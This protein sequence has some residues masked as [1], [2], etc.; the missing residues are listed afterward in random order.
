MAAVFASGTVTIMGRMNPPDARVSREAQGRDH[1]PI[2]VDLDGTL[3]RTDV[4]WES[5]VSALRCNVWR[6]LCGLA[7]LRHGKAAMKRALADAGPVDAAL[8]PYNEIFVEWLRSE[9][10]RGRPLILATAAD[11]ALAKSVAA[12]LGFFVDVIASDGRRNL[13]GLGKLDA[14]QAHRGDGAFA[15]CGNGPE[16]I[17]I[18]R[19][20]DEAILV[21]G[22]ARVQARASELPGV[23]R[24]FS[25]GET[26]WRTWLRGMRAHQWLKNLLVLVPLVTA[27][28][29]N[30]AGMVAQAFTAFVA[31][32][33]VASGGYFFNDLMDLHAD[34][35]HP[36]KRRRPLA[37]GRL[38]VQS[39][40]AAAAGMSTGGLA[41]GW[42]ISPPFAAWLFG[43]ALLTLAYSMAL[44]R[45]AIVDLI[46]LAAL[47]TTR[48]LAGGAAI[49]VEVSFWL[50]AFSGFLF[51]SLATVK[52]CG[53]LLQVR[54]RSEQLAPGRGYVVADLELLKSF[55]V[56][57]SV[58]AVLVLALYVQSPEVAQRYATPR[59]LW[60]VLAV[61]LTWL[62]HLWLVTSR[63]QMH[64]DPLVFALRDP[65]SRWLILVMGAAFAGAAMLRLG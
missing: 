10:A 6:A 61:L 2:Y 21:G 50:L 56:A 48:V 40:V 65:M 15:Y 52:R 38:P 37:S 62:S 4:L 39:G 54:N 16:D 26:D 34:R 9:A 3:I 47:Y 17:D 41:L 44:K 58:A 51:F 57:T 46:A 49:G 59:A 35:A 5:L 20:A 18:F 36:T 45:A 29:L 19:A 14:I 8:L 60:L 42:M 31:F 53:E 13:K 27:F 7:Q 30:D 63:G 32:C 43:Y 1:M 12:H 64:D 24:R 25:A 23:V 33:L 22:S 28:G 11:Q 55:G